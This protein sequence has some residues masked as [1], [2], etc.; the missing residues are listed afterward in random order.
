MA[1]QTATSPLGRTSISPGEHL[2]IVLTGGCVE[3]HT[4]SLRAV[5]GREMEPYPGA[6][7]MAETVNVCLSLVDEYGY[8][9]EGGATQEAWEWV[10]YERLEAIPDGQECAD[11][12]RQYYRDFMADMES[13]KEVAGHEPK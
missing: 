1:T 11:Y 4:A 8:P 9:Q 10:L 12:C 5:A 13:R 3:G 7:T 2:A 6:E